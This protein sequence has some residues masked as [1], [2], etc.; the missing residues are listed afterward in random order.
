MVTAKGRER[1]FRVIMGYRFLFEQRYKRRPCV[2][3]WSPKIGGG[4]ESLGQDPA[5]GLQ[6]MNPIILVVR[7]AM[8]VR[9]SG[10]VVPELFGI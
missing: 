2:H 8:F 9:S 5:L 1:R 6:V 10:S 7:V 4:G 3:R